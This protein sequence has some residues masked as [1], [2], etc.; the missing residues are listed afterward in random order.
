MRFCLSMAYVLG[1]GGRKEYDTEE[2]GQE[3]EN[4]IHCYPQDYWH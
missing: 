1:G 3:R 2:K 4:G